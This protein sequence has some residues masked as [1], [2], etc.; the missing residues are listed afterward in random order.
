MATLAATPAAASL[1]LHF[2]ELIGG[3]PEL[4]AARSRRT[5]VDVDSVADAIKSAVRAESDERDGFRRAPVGFRRCW[6]RSA[7]R[8]PAMKNWVDRVLCGFQ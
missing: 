7:G 8:T 3:P 4:C 1:D 5:I 6:S 2:A